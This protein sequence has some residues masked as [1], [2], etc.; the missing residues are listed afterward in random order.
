MRLNQSYKNIE[1]LRPYGF[2]GESYQV[3]KELIPILFNLNQ[4]NW[5]G[6][7]TFKL[8]LQGQH[9][10]DTKSRQRHCKKI[11]GQYLE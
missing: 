5:R 2:T 8:S 11:I 9:Y 7:K 4:I 3:F 10:L 6:G 1:N